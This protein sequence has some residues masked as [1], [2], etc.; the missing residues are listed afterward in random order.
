MNDGELILKVGGQQVGRQAFKA[1]VRQTIALNDVHKHLHAGGNELSI[2]LTGENQMP[3]AIDVSYRTRKP[4]SSNL[5][6]VRLETELA[7][8]KVEAGD[9]V[10]LAVRLSNKSGEGQP[11]TIAIVGIPAGLEPRHK[12]LEELR[13][14]GEYDFYEVNGRELVFY[15][16][17]LGPDVKGD[18]QIEFNLDLI[19]EIP[20]KYMGPAS[21]TYLYYTAENKHWVD[22]LE[23]QIER[24]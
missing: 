24:N 7:S 18:N 13:K 19:A 21:R 6:P 3:Y 16:R 11:M 17:S 15:W 14:D 10:D 23:V 12:Q 20:G 8:D 1:D 5:C 22:P 2:E 4:V 9:T